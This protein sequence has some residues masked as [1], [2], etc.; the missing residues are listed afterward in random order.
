MRQ[1]FHEEPAMKR[2]IDTLAR[3]LGGAFG[4]G[5]ESPLLPEARL[6][7][8]MPWVIAIMIGLTVVAAASALALRHAA[9]AASA[10]LEGGVTVQIVTA[11]PHERERQAAAALAL[12]RHTP[13]VASASAVP[14]Q[15]LDALV[16]PWLG[17]RAGDDLDAL[18]IPALIDV[19]LDGPASPRRL[20]ALRGAIVHAAPT[21][22]VDAQSSWL[23][24]VFHA[25][26]TLQWAAGGMIA[27]FAFATASAVLLAARNALGIHRE[28]IEVVHMLGATDVQIARVFQ[29]S[30]A[31]DAALGGVV[32]LMAGVVTVL[33]LGRQFATLGSGM[34][35]QGALAWTD[36][37]ALAMIPIAGVLLVMVTARLTVLSALRRML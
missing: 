23:A 21:A 26:G 27:L 16:E 1:P 8:P 34:V 24:P 30:M 12:L 15:Q 6:S 22:R 33:G 28:T 35:A 4:G 25:I 3:T 9:Q 20:D 17:A 10:D 14:Q 37:T 5:G 18:P 29:R 31:T 7:G 36:W 2:L 13:G 32:G 11:A 19:R